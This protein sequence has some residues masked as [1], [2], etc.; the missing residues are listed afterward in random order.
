VRSSAVI[1][2]CLDGRTL[3]YSPVVPPAIKTVRVRLAARLSRRLSPRYSSLDALT[4]GASELRL[5]QAEDALS[6]VEGPL[7]GAGLPTA[8]VR[9]KPD[10]F[11]VG[12]A[13]GDRVGVGG[14]ETHGSEGLLR[15]VVV[16]PP[17]RGREVGTALCVALERRARADGVDTL[18]LLTTTAAGFFADCGYAAIDRSVVPAAIRE[19]DEFADLCP[20]T[21]TGCESP[22]DSRSGG[23]ASIGRWAVGP[24]CSP[25]RAC[26]RRPHKVLVPHR[27]CGI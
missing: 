1:A 13:G 22:C 15:S 24:G 21:A 2:A 17:A 14:V 5:R 20:S 19:T 10:C 18:Y 27:A 26:I 16:D 23:V 7:S 25:R 9:S 11:Y 12:Y 8:D 3:G 6:Y 4:G